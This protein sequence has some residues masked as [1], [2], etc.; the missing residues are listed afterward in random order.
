MKE[1]IK[2]E[3]LPGCFD[4]FDG[5]QEELDSFIQEIKDLVSSGKIFE[6]A[7]PIDFSEESE[8]TLEILNKMMNFID[9]K[10][11]VDKRKKTLN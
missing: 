3:F 9:D 7:E 11:F 10:N 8:E 6:E 2:I 5:T 4:N 1:D